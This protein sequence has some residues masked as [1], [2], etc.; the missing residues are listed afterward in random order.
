VGIRQLVLAEVK[1]SQIQTQN[2]NN[3]IGLFCEDARLFCGN[4]GLFCGSI[5][6]FCVTIGLLKVK[7]VSHGAEFGEF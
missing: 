1:N 5:G 2:N 6:L 7:F 4:M 3:I